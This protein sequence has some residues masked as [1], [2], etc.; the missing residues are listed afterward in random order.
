MSLLQQLINGLVLGHAYA[1]IAIGWTLLLGVARL[2]NFGHGQMYMLGA[3]V[4]WWATTTAGL[5]YLLALPLAMAAGALIGIIMQ[6]I[7]L[8]ATFEQ[9]LVSI[10]IMTLGFGYVMHGAA[11][12]AFGSTG[13]IL[14]TAWSQRD[15]E[16]GDL[17]LTWQDAAIVA[18]AILLFLLLKR[19]LDGSRAGRLVRMVA[20]DPKLAQLAGINVRQVYYGV[21]AF[22]GAAV[23]LAAGLV[24]PRTPILTSMGFEEVIITFVVVVLGGI[25]SVTGSYVAGVALGV[26]TALFS[27]LVSPAYATAAAFVVLIGVLVLRPGGLTAG[28]M[29]GVH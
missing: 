27:A 9:N 15:I 29:K 6:R 5:P 4:T 20:E 23:A 2:V 7:M 14:D 11:S 13:Q 3:F 26:F 10:M 8:R 19:V 1:L 24:A 28:S 18:A 21:F 25:G 17:W 16:I 12:L 22:E